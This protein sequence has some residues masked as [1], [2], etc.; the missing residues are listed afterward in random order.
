VEDL[1]NGIS[2]EITLEMMKRAPYADMCHFFEQTAEIAV[3][4]FSEETK[5]LT[6]YTEE[7]SAKYGVW[8]GHYA[9]AAHTN[10]ML[11]RLFKTITDSV[12]TSGKSQGVQIITDSGVFCDKMF[13]AFRVRILPGFIIP[14]YM[15]PLAKALRAEALLCDIISANSWRLTLGEGESVYLQSIGEKRP[16]LLSSLPP[17]TPRSRVRAVHI[18]YE[19]RMPE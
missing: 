7:D 14:E 12:K 2:E 5:K 10:L 18:S 16:P 17:S 4:L 15:N 8:Y 19:I 3:L 9:L 1:S 13:Q 6:E 11:R